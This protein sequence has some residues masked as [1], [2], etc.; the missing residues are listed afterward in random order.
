MIIVFFIKADGPNIVN[1]VDE[2]MKISIGNHEDEYNSNTSLSLL[3]QYM[4]HF[5][6]TKQYYSFNYQNIHF[7]VMST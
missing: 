1:L 3:N 4:Y 5:G 2:K 7:V 6:L